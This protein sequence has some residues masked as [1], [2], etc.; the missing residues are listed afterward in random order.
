MTVLLIHSFFTIF[1]TGLI[2]TI[3]IVHYPLFLKVGEQN[4][5]DYEGQHT[6]KISRLVIP[7]MIFELI[8]S[9]LLVHLNGIESIFGLLL[10]LLSFIWLST[11]LI[12]VP[13]H[14][15]LSKAYDSQNIYRLVHTNWIRTLI[16]TI[17]S[18]ILIS[19]LDELTK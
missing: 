16:W 14:R 19:V 8:T 6:S 18:F 17:R 10:L 13:L 2:W 1:N 4:F 3:Q 11:F 12:Q 5:L 15:S 7:S 9:I